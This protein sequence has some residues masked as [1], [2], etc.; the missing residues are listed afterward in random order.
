M[1][2][3]VSNCA[4]ICG[5]HYFLNTMRALKSKLANEVLRTGVSI[6]LTPGASFTHNNTKY[7][8]EFVPK[9][10]SS[11][12]VSRKQRLHLGFVGLLLLLG[13][14]SSTALAG[15]FSTYSYSATPS[16]PSIPTLPAPPTWPT[17]PSAPATPT[18]GSPSWSYDYGAQQ[19]RYRSQQAQ[20]QLEYQLQMQDSPELVRS[21]Q[22][23]WL[24]LQEAS[25]RQDANFAAQRE[26]QERLGRAPGVA[27]EEIRRSQEAALRARNDANSQKWYKNNY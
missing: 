24:L 13:T 1:L 14:V 19:D 26:A 4:K 9:A 16:M 7:I 5:N 21:Q 25:R 27:A 3:R 11:T 18:F 6:P 15:P 10:A 23:Q 2:P 12:N 22:Q 17:P 8:I 20:R